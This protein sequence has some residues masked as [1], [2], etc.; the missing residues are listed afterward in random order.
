MRKIKIVFIITGLSTGGAEMMLL[1]LLERV[2]LEKFEPSVIS[3]TNRGEIGARIESLGIPLMVLNMRPEFPNPLILINIVKSLKKIKPDIVHTWMYHADL[4]GGVAARLAGCQCVIWGIHHSNLSKNVNKRS[5]LLVVKL[6]AL[7]SKFVPRKILLCSKRAQSIHSEAGYNSK[8][9]YVIPNGIDIE[10]FSPDGLAYT[11]VRAELSLPIGT[12]LVGLIAR[13]DSQKNHIGFIDAAAVIYANR[14]DVHF[15]L[16]GAQIDNSNK[17]L[18]AAILKN[19]LSENVHLLG[20]REDVS[21]LMASLDVLASSSHG[22]A[23][24]NV[25]GEAMACGVSCVV[26]DVGDCAEI[27]EGT[28]RSVAANDMAGLAG[29]VLEILN[30]KAEDKKNLSVLARQRVSDKYEI[31]HVVSLYEDFYLEVL[32]LS[33]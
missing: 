16:A 28:G 22:E 15:L 2:D 30:L 18:T 33:T 5:T 23:F 8:K 25:L 10:R 29:A 26:T 31:K 27:I 20:R 12:P 14:T 24:P 9:F 1:K 13:F 17:D 11:S 3:L 21:R 32:K 7:L 4:I 6:C 19:G